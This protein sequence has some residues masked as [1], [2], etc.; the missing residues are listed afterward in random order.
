MKLHHA[1][2]VAL[3]ALSC[4]GDEGPATSS[5]SSAS[6][7]G[8]ATSSAGSGG[9]GGHGAT[10]SGGATGGGGAGGAEID[11]LADLPP[12]E[13]VDGGYQF[14]EGP[15]WFGASGVLRFSDIPQNRIH[16][17]APPSTITVFR[18]PSGNSNGLGVDEA[19]RLVAC[20]H[21][22]RRVS[23][24]LADQSIVSIAD[25]WEG[26]KLNSPNDVIIRSDGTVY[27]TDPPYG[28]SPAD[29][30]LSFQGVFRIAPGGALDLVADDMTAPNGIA[31][32]PDEA[33]LYVTDSEEHELH[34]F[35]VAADGTTGPREKL[36]D[37][38]P[39]PDGMAVDDAGNLYLSTSAGI[40]VRRPDGS[41]RG[42]I[43]VPEQP[44]NCAFGGSDRRTLFITAQ[45]SLYRLAAKIPGKP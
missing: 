18:E 13:L 30:E 14:L 34:R 24:T 26:K 16:E 37:T 33:T 21:G 6:G 29:R 8:G 4:G 41:L 38:A 2:A 11:P 12:V 45:T 31:L 40:E 9:A 10:G 19:G 27:F 3:A 44:A 28:V 23:R 25:H 35:S 36:A 1:I 17:L 20:E 43:P 42:T 22:N 15:A 5:A 32:S 39:V 7:S